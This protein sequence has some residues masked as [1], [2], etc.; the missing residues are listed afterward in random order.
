MNF[1]MSLT[2]KKK[3]NHVEANQVIQFT[4]H[5]RNINTIINCNDS[6]GGIV[7]FPENSLAKK[8]GNH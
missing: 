7:L 5:K 1:F 4:H 3:K 6:F 2:K 8:N